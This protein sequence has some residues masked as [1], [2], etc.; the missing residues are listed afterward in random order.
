MFYDVD[1]GRPLLRRKNAGDYTPASGCGHFNEKAEQLGD[2]K[3][4]AE[5]HNTGIEYFIL[6]ESYYA[7]YKKN[8]RTC[9]QGYQP[10]KGGNNRMNQECIRQRPVSIEQKPGSFHTALNP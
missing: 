7:G 5:R 3:I 1:G 10:Y 2:G 8:R 9:K 6:I 4:Y